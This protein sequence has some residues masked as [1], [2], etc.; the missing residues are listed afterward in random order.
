MR[1]LQRPK[2][3]RRVILKDGKFRMMGV[4]LMSHLHYL[5]VELVKSAR[6]Y[7]IDGTEGIFDVCIRDIGHQCLRACTIRGQ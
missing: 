7:A 6:S 2:A 1:E 5:A 4:R 3:Q